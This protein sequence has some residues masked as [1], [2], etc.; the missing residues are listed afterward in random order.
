MVKNIS[1]FEKHWFVLDV[2]VF[3]RIYF[4][5]HLFL[6]VIASFSFYIL[7]LFPSFGFNQSSRVWPLIYMFYILSVFYSSWTVCH[8][9]WVLYE[10]G[11]PNKLGVGGWKIR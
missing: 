8:Y 5:T 2:D 7:K 1:V 9:L 11:G 6:T 3:F 10:W 4:E